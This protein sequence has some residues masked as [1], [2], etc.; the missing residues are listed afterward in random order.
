LAGTYV[1]VW[2]GNERKEAMVIPTDENG[3]ARLQLTDKD[4]EIDIHS[5]DPVVRYNNLL[6]INVPYVLC[7]SHTQ[8][9]SWLALTSFSTEQVIQRGIVTPNSCGLAA[10]PPKPEEVI[11]FVRPLNWWE[12][13][14][15]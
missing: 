6:R 4:S 2:V 15:Q 3:V 13:L 1:N 12:K 5:R 11:I 10:A 9:Y 7:Q 8:D 14:K